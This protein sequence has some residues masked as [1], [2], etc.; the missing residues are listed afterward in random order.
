[1]KIEKKIL[2][3]EEDTNIQNLCYSYLSG[4]YDKV[5]KAFN[6]NEA[7]VILKECAIDVALVALNIPG[8]N[9]LDFIEQM[10][11]KYPKVNF[12]IMSEDISISTL[13]NSI[14]VGVFDFIGKPF[15][16]T[17]LVEKVDK[18]SQ[19]AEVKSSVSL[20]LAYDAIQSERETQK[21]L[22]LIEAKERV[23]EAFNSHFP[24]KA[25][26]KKSDITKAKIELLYSSL[27]S[28]LDFD[29]ADTLD[30]TSGGVLTPKE[31]EVWQLLGAGFSVKDISLRKT[32]STNTV[33]SHIKSIRR[34]LGL[35][36]LGKSANP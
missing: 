28:A 36:R 31:R 13:L 22:V 9:G 4:H 3:L 25:Q 1:M 34:K 16:L 2:V 24:P 23:I 17:T 10:K 35:V 12:I 19:N 26:L 5:L 15:S 33:Q 14:R 7:N 6:T 30:T 8:G 21:K 29:K 20:K 11:S 27:T 32:R 18:A